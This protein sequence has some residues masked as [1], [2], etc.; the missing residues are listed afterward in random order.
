MRL[1][2]FIFREIL[3]RVTIRESKTH[4]ICLNASVESIVG[5]VLGPWHERLPI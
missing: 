5:K 2:F 3:E 4:A 1:Y